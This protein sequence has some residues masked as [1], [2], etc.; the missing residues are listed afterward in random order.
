MHLLFPN[1]FLNWGRLI[2]SVCGRSGEERRLL[3]S[4]EDNLQLILQQGTSPGHKLLSDWPHVSSGPPRLTLHCARGRAGE[5]CWAIP[6]TPV[7]FALRFFFSL[8]FHNSGEIS[9]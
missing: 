7:Q 5:R 1:A 6:T 4:E 2:F 3:R 8:I 9:V